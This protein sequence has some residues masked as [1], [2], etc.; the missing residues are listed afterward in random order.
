MP[1]TNSLKR[2]VRRVMPLEFRQTAAQTRREIKDWSS[3][4]VFPRLRGGDQWPSRVEI[5][6]PVMPSPLIENKLSNVRRGA[7]LIDMSQMEPDG[8]WSFWSQVGRPSARN[9]FVSGR[10]LVNGRLVTQIGGG[11]CQLSSLIYHLALQ[12]GLDIVERH[13]HSIDIYREEDRFTPL[14]SDA[15]VVWGFKDLRL[16]NPHPF[17]VSIGCMLHEMRLTGQI[18]SAEALPKHVIDFVADDVSLGR[19]GVKTIINGAEQWQT[20][21]ERR[22]D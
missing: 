9:G 1:K 13:A 2:F 6:Q 16:H 18:R 8:C 4:I 3:G 14:G 15:T 17:P 21:Y 5:T 22:P 7:S 12:S 19:V 11:L 20:Y 10:N